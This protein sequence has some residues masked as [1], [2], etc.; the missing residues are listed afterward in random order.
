MRIKEQ[1]QIK[2]ILSNFKDLKK[3]SKRA[4]TD[5]ADI[6]QFQGLKKHSKYK[7]RW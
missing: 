5:K 7:T 2:Q 3:H 1:Q 6:K 4:A